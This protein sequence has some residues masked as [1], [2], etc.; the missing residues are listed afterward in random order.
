MLY[1][2][3]LLHGIKGSLSAIGQVQFAKNIAYVFG[4]GALMNEKLSC[5][6]LITEAPGDQAEC[7]K[8]ARR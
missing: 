2:Q 7:F 6:L 5:N 4:D 1:G 8:L 3:A